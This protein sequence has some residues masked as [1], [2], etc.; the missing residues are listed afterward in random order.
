[1]RYFFIILSL[2]FFVSMKGQVKPVTPG[3]RNELDNKYSPGK[4]PAVKTNQDDVSS[5]SSSSDPDFKNVIKCNIALFPRCI[6]A[7]CYQ[8]FIADEVSLEGWLG[9]VYKKDP[10]FAVFGSAIELSAQYGALNLKDIYTYG[11]KKGIR[12][13]LGASVKFH[14]SGLASWNENNSFIEIGARS[15][16]HKLDLSP[17]ETATAKTYTPTYLSGDHTVIIKHLNYLVNFGFRFTTPGKIK[18]SHEF[19]T[20]LGWR[21][22]TYDNFIRSEKKY[23]TGSGNGYYYEYSKNGTR[24]SGSSPLFVIGYILGFGF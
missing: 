22:F 3:S 21:T 17:I 19:Y 14:F 5:G 9:A 16:S 1:V 8:Y 20:G 15:Y 7:F 18:T 4:S 13:Y 12:P 6:A 24:K 10:I 11:V 23:Q 2:V